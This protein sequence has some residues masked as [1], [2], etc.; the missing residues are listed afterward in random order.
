MLNNH[1]KVGMAS[2]FLTTLLFYHQDNNTSSLETYALMTIIILSAAEPRKVTAFSFGTI[3][4]I[5]DTVR[6]SGTQVQT[7]RGSYQK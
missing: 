7:Q 4:K 1:E 3:L 5:E 2:N 6:F